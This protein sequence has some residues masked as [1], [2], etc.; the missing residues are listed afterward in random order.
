[1]LNK[2]PKNWGSIRLEQYQELISLDDSEYNS[3]SVYNLEILSIITDTDKDDDEWLDMDVDDLFKIYKE[4]KWLLSEPSSNKK[5]NINNLLLKEF[6][7]LNLGEFI[8]L[9]H[10]F[11]EDYIKNLHI[12]CAILYKKNKLD[13][14]DNLIFEPY[15]Y[16]IFERS[17]QFLEEPITNV[18]GIIKEYLSWK[19]NFVESYNIFQDEPDITEEEMYDG[20]DED[21][22]KEL[23]E[24]L[25]KGESIKK[26][27]WERI[28]YNLCNSDV[29]KFNDVLNMNIILVFNIL[30]MKNDLKL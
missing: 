30:S 20:L 10:F 7:S 22:I 28:I 24:D 12:I 18:Y 23:Q 29:T 14:W 19:K 15:E 8:D 16:N 5:S 25:E 11:S 2:I 9:E 17:N 13:E 3:L 1:M 21:E 27:N 26:W 4:T 6:N